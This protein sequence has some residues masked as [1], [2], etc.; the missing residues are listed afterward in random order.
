MKIHS[1]VFLAFLVEQARI[2]DTDLRTGTTAPSR[3]HQHESHLN[4][5]KPELRFTTA[6]VQMESGGGCPVCKGDH[7]VDR[8]PRFRSYSVQQRRHWAM[9][10]K[11]CFVFLGR[12]HRRERCPKSKSNQFWNVLLTGDS[13]PVGKARTKHAS[14][15][16]RSDGTDSAEAKASISRS[17]EK[18]T[19]PVGIHLSSTEGQ[20]TIRLPVVRALAHGEKG[21]SKLVNCLLDSGSE[22]SLIRTEVEDELDLQGPTSAMT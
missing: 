11:L 14:S 15:A 21:K 2:K 9:R 6:A 22:R 4:A 8:C 19:S 5:R 20:T 7:L 12:G 10:L 17:S 16:V 13:V 1:D 3:G 18:G